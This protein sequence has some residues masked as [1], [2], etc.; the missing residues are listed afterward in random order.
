MA[1][2]QFDVKIPQEWSGLEEAIY[3][4][5]A[6][7]MDSMISKLASE[8]GPCYIFPPPYPSHFDFPVSILG[9]E[10]AISSSKQARPRKTTE[11]AKGRLPWQVSFQ[12]PELPKAPS[13]EALRLMS[14]LSPDT[15]KAVKE[16]FEERPI[17]TRTYAACKTQI[18]YPDLARILPV[19]SN[20]LTDGPYR[21]AWVK[22]G[23]DPRSDPS[24]RQYQ[25]IH[26]RNT[27]VTEGLVEA[28]A[29][30]P[31]D[32]AY[33]FTGQDNNSTVFQLC[34]LQHPTLQKIVNDKRGVQNVCTRIDG[35]YP[36]GTIKKLRS[37]MRSVWL[38]QLEKRNP[39]Q[40]QR[41]MQQRSKA[42]QKRPSSQQD[43]TI[44]NDSEDDE[45]E[46]SE[47]EYEY[48]DE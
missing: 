7:L 19:F 29:E 8:P 13:N 37:I 35:W 45:L 46:E 6:G 18:S 9:P 28:S 32:Q 44:D 41:V 10:L 30:E 12:E 21:L 5:D 2:F 3:G 39:E 22:Y 48:Y 25:V 23:V 20:C 4:M 14:Y 40:H 43:S 26:C 15:V 31:V 27:L 36:S 38:E 47:E 24:F 11:I 42:A 17:L 34:D 1:E 16:I 33:L